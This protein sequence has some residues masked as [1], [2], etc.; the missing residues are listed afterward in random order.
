M[1][2]T[3]HNILSVHNNTTLM[4][5]PSSLWTQ[6]AFTMVLGRVNVLVKVFIGTRM[7]PNMCSI[8][9]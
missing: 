9:H 5:L 7:V 3:E 2:P 8:L 6:M 1:G 4:Q